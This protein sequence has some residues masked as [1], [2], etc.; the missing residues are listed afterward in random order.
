MR[1]VNGSDLFVVKPFV[2]GETFKQ[3][4]RA[5]RLDLHETLRIGIG[6]VLAFDNLQKSGFSPE[7]RTMTL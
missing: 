3:R 6:L 7:Q 1:R 2:A 4:I 5:G